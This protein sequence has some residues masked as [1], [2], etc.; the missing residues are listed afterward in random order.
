MSPLSRLRVALTVQVLLGLVRFLA[1]YAGVGIDQRIWV[2]DAML[3]ITIA[4]SALWL[5][6]RRPTYPRPPRARQRGSS[7]SP[8]CCWGSPTSRAS[9]RDSPWC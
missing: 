8:H 7:P 2:V 6:P 3:G 5:F 4:V 9:R 1:P